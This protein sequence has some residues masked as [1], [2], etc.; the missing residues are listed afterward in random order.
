MSTQLTYRVQNAQ[1]SWSLTSLDPTTLRFELRSQD[2]WAQDDSSSQR[3]E[4]AI[5]GLY[6]PRTPITVSYNFTVEPGQANTASW[7]V[8]GQFHNN[9]TTT[10]PPFAVMMYGEH[11][12][13]VAR[14]QLPGQSNQT[15]MRL[16][17]DPNP[18]QRGHSYSMNI[19]VDF[20]NSG[21]GYLHVW[22]DGVEIV[23]YQGP[24][25]YGQQVYWKEGIYRADAPQTIAV[26]YQNLDIAIPSSDGILIAQGATASSSS[27]NTGSTSPSGSST[28]DSSSS[29]TNAG[30]SSS[31]GL[32]TG[33][34]SSISSSTGS[35]SLGS[36]SAAVS[37]DP[38]PHYTHHHHYATSNPSST[39]VSSS[40]S[41]GTGGTSS[42]GLSAGASNDPTPHYTHH[43]HHA[44]S[45]P[46]S[47]ATSTASGDPLAT[48]TSTPSTMLATLTSLHSTQHAPTALGDDLAATLSGTGDPQAT[49][50]SKASTMMAIFTGI[51]GTENDSTV[52][53]DPMGIHTTHHPDWG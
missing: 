14:Y 6:D 19:D 31:D 34:S 13:I 16:Y 47:A 24:I 51:H 4:I 42:T 52:S 9:D 18:I 17:E 12:A 26:D 10:S 1:D 22:R 35:T 11:M 50:S 7:M 49:L 37:N 29:S 36:S 15:Y 39:G 3:S 23:N 46:S 5:N 20:D 43:N 21:N 8:L 33:D 45:N 53:W 48:L 30:V 28:G 2:H 27:S 41:S 32:S 44:T 40:I 38:T 25:G